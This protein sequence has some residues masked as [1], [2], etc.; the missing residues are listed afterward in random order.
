MEEMVVNYGWEGGEE[1]VRWP[2]SPV[3]MAVGTDGGSD[4]PVTPGGDPIEAVEA[5]MRL[6][7]QATE[8]GTM[9]GTDGRKEAGAADQQEDGEAECEADCEEDHP[10][11]TD[12]EDHTHGTVGE[13]QRIEHPEEQQ[14]EGQ[15][16][17]R[18]EE[19]EGDQ[20]PEEGGNAMVEDQ[21]QEEDQEITE[22]L[23]CER[24]GSGCEKRSRMG[25]DE[26]CGGCMAKHGCMSCMMRGAAVIGVKERDR[27]V[28]RRCR[29]RGEKAAEEEVEQPAVE[30][31]GVEHGW[32]SGISPKRVSEQMAEAKRR[33]VRDFGD[34]DD[35]EDHGPQWVTTSTRGSTSSSDDDQVQK[36]PKRKRVL[37]EEEAIIG[38][39]GVAPPGETAKERRLR[40]HRIANRRNTAK[41]NAIRE[42]KERIRLGMDATEEQMRWV[43]AQVQGKKDMTKMELAE[44]AMDRI[45]GGWGMTDAQ[46][47]MV[48]GLG[49]KDQKKAEQIKGG[50]AKA[51]AKKES[52]ERRMEEAIRVECALEEEDLRAKIKYVEMPKEVMGSLREGTVLDRITLRGMMKR[53]GKGDKEYK[54]MVRSTIA[55]YDFLT[56]LIFLE[57]K[58]NVPAAF[59][60]RKD[61]GVEELRYM[62]LRVWGNAVVGVRMPMHLAGVYLG[63]KG[64]SATIMHSALVMLG[65][66]G[67]KDA[68]KTKAEVATMARDLLLL[69]WDAD[70]NKKRIQPTIPPRPLDQ[71]KA[72]RSEEEGGGKVEIGREEVEY[73]WTKTVETRKILWGE[74]GYSKASRIASETVARM[75]KA[76]EQRKEQNQKRKRSGG[77][78]GGAAVGAAVGA[79]SSSPSKLKIH[80]APVMD[81]SVPAIKK[82][83]INRKIGAPYHNEEGR[84]VF[85]MPNGRDYMMVPKKKLQVWEMDDSD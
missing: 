29:R 77:A 28:C 30:R 45:R 73:E 35:H 9:G 20:D 71:F 8:G 40:L 5:M 76:T 31:G 36:E 43:L 12:Q 33:K 79:A 82:K 34:E 2:G 39:D 54:E 10:M 23:E 3:G 18:Q 46:K 80:L 24:C 68:P 63:G 16:V 17:E 37:S 57:M 19:E 59:W 55:R 65:V 22:I 44:R 21:D 83:I 1:K 32:L 84:I 78:A 15:A 74:D 66:E 41:N 58:V 67:S 61:Y 48:M 6:W 7:E 52:E 25:E 81:E 85:Q 47:E 50:M 42:A 13:E 27:K 60:M 14:S 72:R 69:V 70:V 11:V 53:M 51:K 75:K 64:T 26:V 38:K 56:C 49:S 4:E 62:L